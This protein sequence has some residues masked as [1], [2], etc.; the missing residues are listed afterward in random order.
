MSEINFEYKMTWTDS[1][2]EKKQKFVYGPIPR[3]H[4]FSPVYENFAD[5]HVSSVMDILIESVKYELEKEVEK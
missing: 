2:G 1:N 5:R 4:F 3:H